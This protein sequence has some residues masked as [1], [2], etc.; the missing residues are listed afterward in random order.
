MQRAIFRPRTLRLY[1]PLIAPAR[2]LSTARPINRPKPS[3]F[4]IASAIT[5]GSG[6]LIYSS[7]RPPAHSE[8]LQPLSAFTSSTPN[9]VQAE[10]DDNFNRIAVKSK[11]TSELLLSLAI[12]KACATSWLVD[13][14]PHLI[15][16]AEKVGLS[17]PV[18]WIIKRTF[19]QQFCGGESADECAP[20]MERLSRFGIG[21]ILDLSIEADIDHPGDRDEYTERAD[22]VTQLTKECVRAAAGEGGMAAIKVTAFSSPMMLLN[23]N[24]FFE[25]ARE[26]FIAHM[27]DNGR[28][29]RTDLCNITFKLTSGQAQVDLMP[30][31][32][33]EV[34][35][36]DYMQLLSPKNSAAQTVMTAAGVS[37]DDINDFKSCLV[38]LEQVCDMA[39]QGQ[40]KIMVDA[41]QSYFQRTIDH[42]AMHLQSKYNQRTDEDDASSP[43]VL[44]TYQMY[45]KDAQSK[46]AIDAEQARRQGFV[47]GAKLVRGA[48][49]HS[50]RK[51]AAELGIPSPICDT[52]EDTHN[53]YNGGVIFLLNKIQQHAIET[54]QPISLKTT[55]IVF[56][57][58]SHNRESVKLT[59]RE[60]D[61]N[62]VL[63]RTGVVTFGQL[64]GMQD[65]ISYCLG[66][67]GY[68]I[69]KYLPYG[70]IQ[71]VI[72]YLIRRAQENSAIL[73]GGAVAMERQLMWDET[74]TRIIGQ[75]TPEV[76]TAAPAT[77]AAAA[78]PAASSESVY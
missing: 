49:M 57:V 22:A 70:Q 27:D 26:E 46:L 4:A 29:R 69:Y 25:R 71:E 74:K 38:R 21:S 56:M 7:T 76:I 18:Y 20:V 39:K 15:A 77:D 78:T 14:A 50:E 32:E 68:P 55:P 45:T 64:Y 52:L 62:G 36:I 30:L 53:S 24:K 12:Y 11:S 60:M 73:G 5:L 54:N 34:D 10:L 23:V 75:P 43:V 6:Y 59:I 1:Q 41:E 47:F 44:N 33:T 3:R 35:W 9:S 67:N 16:A 42:I 61:K 19:F 63:P 72:P 40:V 28:I 17:A 51:R 8:Q 58:A 37:Q 31:Q 2:L 66:K 65:Q 13:V 48:Y